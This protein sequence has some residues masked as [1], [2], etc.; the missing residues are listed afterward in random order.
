MIRN[1]LD[2]VEPQRRH[3]ALLVGMLVLTFV[4]TVVL[5]VQARQA[6]LARQDQ[7]KE[8]L[9]DLSGR[10]AVE[11]DKALES[12]VAGATVR[13]VVGAADALEA[14]PT[15]PLDQVTS[16]FNVRLLCGECSEVPAATYF[17]IDLASGEL[18]MSAQG[19][20]VPGARY[21][22]L[23]RDRIG[24]GGFSLLNDNNG[25]MLIL[26]GDGGATSTVAV[27]VLS[28]EGR[29]VRTVGYI[30]PTAVLA[31]AFAAT[32]RQMPLLPAPMSKGMPNDS[33]L[34][35]AGDGAAAG[36]AGGGADAAACGLRVGC[37]ARVAYA[38]GA[39]PHVH[40][41]AA[42]GPRAV[43][44][45]APAVAGDHRPGGAAS[46][47][48]GGERAAVLEDGGRPPCAGGAGADAFR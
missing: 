48:S 2:R 46:G 23:V 4:L 21:V 32:F 36:P 42:A 27:V 18:Q 39:D 25:V 7:S 3:L 34:R 41:D 1:L 31:D 38:A 13:S 14:D 45:G 40:G 24:A 15:L 44:C 29:P 19:G 22:E 9:R 5:A 17:S 10:A 6:D 16:L 26:D 35:P 11:W 20:P 43:G 28:A 37:V 30:V 8:L 33:D 47:A 12:Q